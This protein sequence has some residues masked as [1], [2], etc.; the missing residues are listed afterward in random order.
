MGISDCQPDRHGASVFRD[1]GRE[2][3]FG[4]KN[5]AEAGK[6]RP[7]N[8]D[9]VPAVAT[10]Q[11]YE[12]LASVPMDWGPCYDSPDSIR[13]RIPASV[14]VGSLYADFRSGNRLIR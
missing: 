9:P 7:A 4:R 12:S 2:E 10:H 3:G 11:C 8:G 1:P 14:G 5:R 13:G 6:R